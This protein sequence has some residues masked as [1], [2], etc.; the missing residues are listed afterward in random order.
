VFCK[1]PE[2][3]IR[4]GYKVPEEPSTDHSP[5]RLGRFNGTTSETILNGEFFQRLHGRTT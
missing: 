5:T 1:F 2:Y 3:L 4:N